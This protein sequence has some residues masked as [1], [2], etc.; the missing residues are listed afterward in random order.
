MTGQI[1]RAKRDL[2]FAT[3]LGSSILI[4]LVVFALNYLKFGQTSMEMIPTILCGSMNGRNMA[5]VL[6]L[7]PS[8]DLRSSIS[9]K[10]FNGLVVPLF[11]CIQT[12]HKF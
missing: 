2:S 8:L 12:H 6:L 1:R 10:E 11:L 7:I 4:N 9:I 5:L 3:G